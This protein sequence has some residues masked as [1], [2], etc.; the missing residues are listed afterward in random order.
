VTAC[1]CIASSIADCVFGVARLI[2]S[3]SAIWVKIGPDWN[4]KT[5][6]PDAVWATRF[7]AQDVGGMRSGVNWMRLNL[8]CSTLPSV[9]TSS[10]LPSPGTPFEQAVAAG[11]ERREHA[12]DDVVVAHDHLAQLLLDRLEVLLERR[13]LL[14]GRCRI[15]HSLTSSIPSVSVGISSSRPAVG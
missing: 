11:E 9:R 5:R 4:L 12:A 6:S 14:L 13:D 10:V 15:A 1:S 2:S 7:G 8:S 3:A